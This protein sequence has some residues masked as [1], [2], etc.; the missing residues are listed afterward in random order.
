[1]AN[2]GRDLG[3]LRATVH[4]SPWDELNNKKAIVVRDATDIDSNLYWRQSYVV[5]CTVLLALL[6]L[7]LADSNKATTE[8]IY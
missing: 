3:L 1:M 6:S 8:K 5:L 2:N 4:G 7:R